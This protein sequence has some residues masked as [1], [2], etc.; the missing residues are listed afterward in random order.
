M[1]VH[2]LDLRHL[3]IFGRVVQEGG[4]TQAARS[5]GLTQP[6]VSGHI[7]SLEEEIGTVLFHRG[8]GRARPTA[9]GEM[10][11]QFAARIC[12]L[13]AEALVELEKFLGLRQGELRIGASTTP[14]T[15][16]LPPHLARFSAK[17]PAIKVELTV[18]DTRAI[19]AALE[20]GRIEMALVGDEVDGDRYRARKVASDPIALTV[21]RSHPW[22]SRSKVKLEELRGQPLIVRGEGS[23]T[24]SS[25]VHLLAEKG[26]RI[27]QEI[28]IALRLP[29]NEAIREAVAH[30]ETAAFLPRACLAGREGELRPLELEELSIERPF[31]LVL[32]LSREPGPAA[33]MLMKMFG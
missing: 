15:Y 31:M 12:T 29:T 30:S 14:A 20:E 21:G 9:A 7:H 24:L 23:A 10:L 5:L 17:H 4:I 22:F 32:S 19:L 8:G 3:E 33:K 11:N 13:K 1:I 16:Y 27:G 6:T 18:G 25:V 28:P 26:L 2:G